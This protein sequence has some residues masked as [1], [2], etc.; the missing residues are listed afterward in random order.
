MG[1][2]REEV[3]SRLAGQEHRQAMRDAARSW[4]R[5]LSK[6]QYSRRAGKLDQIDAA[7][8]RL[9]HLGVKFKEWSRYGMTIL[10]T[11]HGLILPYR[12]DGIL[13]WNS[14]SNRRK[15]RAA[16]VADQHPLFSVEM[17]A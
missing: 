9:V 17:T 2:L 5:K 10:T 15:D 3:R 4:R 13:D 14:Y 16:H 8:V 1:Y 7:M 11:E 6:V 12:P